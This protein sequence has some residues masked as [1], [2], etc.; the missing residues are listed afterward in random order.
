MK[1]VC[2][3]SYMYKDVTFIRVLLANFCALFGLCPIKWSIFGRRPFVSRLRNRPRLS[4]CRFVVRHGRILIVGF[5]CD[6]DRLPFRVCLW[7]RSF[8]QGAFVV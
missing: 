8:Y 3:V 6:D 1:E 4:G 7:S 5:D 2:S